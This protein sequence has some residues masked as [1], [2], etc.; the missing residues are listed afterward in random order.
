MEQEEEQEEEIELEDE[1]EEEVTDLFKTP[2]LDKVSENPEIVLQDEKM[3]QEYEANKEIREKFETW[4]KDDKSQVHP[5]FVSSYSFGEHEFERL[6][7]ILFRLDEVAERVLTYRKENMQYFPEFYS[8]LKN[9]F[10]LIRFIIDSTNRKKFIEGFDYVKVAV[11]RYTMENELNLV[12]V[13]ILEEMYSKLTDIKN[14]HGL[15]FSYEKKKGE[16]EKYQ[17]AFFKRRPR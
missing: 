1:A 9:F 14:F 17:E 6:K 16:S 10:T 5:G 15:G 2:L 7:F 4:Q 8:I 12:A 13:Q 11:M 3:K